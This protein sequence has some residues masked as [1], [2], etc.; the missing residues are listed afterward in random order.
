MDESDINFKKNRQQQSKIFGI[1]QQLNQD[2]KWRSPTDCKDPVHNI[3]MNASRAMRNTQKVSDSGQIFPTISVEQS[4]T[5]TAVKREEE[6]NMADA[7]FY[8]RSNNHGY[9]KTTDTAD[10]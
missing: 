5:G 10:S 6:M 1:K 4:P 8:R 7:S 3:S 9:L 2:N